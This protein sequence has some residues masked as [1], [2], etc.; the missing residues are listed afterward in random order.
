MLSLARS[1]PA[2]YRSSRRHFRG[3]ERAAVIRAMTAARLY[4]NKTV[5]TLAAAATAC[6][7]NPPYV[8]A[9]VTMIETENAHLVNRVL[10]GDVGLLEAA[11]DAQRLAG[12]VK[13]YR[14]AAAGDHIA[15]ARVI[16]ATTLFDNAVAPAI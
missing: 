6:G 7:S 1:H 3:H 13:A 15:F 8:R 10:L 2:R 5:P 16:G 14:T 9:A 12:L 11:R 4:M